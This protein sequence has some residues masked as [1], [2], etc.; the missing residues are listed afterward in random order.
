MLDPQGAP[1]ERMVGVGHVACS[2][3]PW[4]GGL[5]VSLTRMPFPREPCGLGQA[6]ARHA[7]PHHDHEVAVDAPARRLRRARV[8]PGA[9]AL[10]RREPYA[11]VQ[12]G[13]RGPGVQL[14]IDRADLASEHMLERNCAALDE[15]DLEALLSRGSGHLGANPTGSDDREPGAGLQAPAQRRRS[16]PACAGTWMPS[17]SAPG[18]VSRRG[19]APVASSSRS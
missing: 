15:R 14:G 11:G 6:R 7:D 4:D 19:R 1:V 8:P 17:S 18:T 3:H 13:R 2:E 12:F 9:V 16:P 10:E 5:E